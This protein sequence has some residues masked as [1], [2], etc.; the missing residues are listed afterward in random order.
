MHYWNKD[1]FE[2][3]KSI[4]EK[5]SSIEGYELFGRYCLQKESGYKK[6]ANVA[7]EQFVAIAKTKSLDKQRETAVEL[8]S[9][10][11][12]N[13]KIHQLLTYPLVTYLTDV[14]K[15]WTSDEPENPTPCKWLGYLVRDISY[16]EKALQLDPNDDI[17]ISQIAQAYISDLDYQ[18]HHLSESL[19]LGDLDHAK[20]T[21]ASAQALITRLTI[22]AARATLNDELGY[23]ANLLSCWEEYLALSEKTSFPDW[24]AS[25]G[26]KFNFWSI[27]YY[28]KL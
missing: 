22:E 7:V 19:F 27:A 11:F 9:L 10:G 2:G 17:C 24:C 13:G 14:L 1:N 4:G 21:L 26:H 3:L 15:Q 5:F 23:Y 16:Y 6:L 8:S 28:E 25:K 12:W 18:T 20:K